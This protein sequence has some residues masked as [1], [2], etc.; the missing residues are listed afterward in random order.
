MDNLEKLVTLGTQD[1]GRRQK[2]IKNT[3]LKTKSMRTRTQQKPDETQVL[4]KV[5]Q[6]L[7]LIR[8]PL[9]YSYIQ[10]SPAKVLAI[11]EERNNLR[12][13]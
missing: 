1:T 10:S 3:T 13:K 6:F 2:L 9:C 12:K 11:I 4:R 7:L 5:K 8:H